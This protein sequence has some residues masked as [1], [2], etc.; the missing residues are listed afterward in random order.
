MA[1]RH[2][3]T[4]LILLCILLPIWRFLPSL[5]V[6]ENPFVGYLDSFVYQHVA[7]GAL[8]AGAIVLLFGRRWG[9]SLAL[10]GL[11]FHI[12]QAGLHVTALLGESIPRPPFETFS[13]GFQL[14]GWIVLFIWLWLPGIQRFT[15]QDS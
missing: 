2:K 11:L 7:D 8:L 14:G 13:L 12:I 1:G 10:G 4:G 15:R 6:L 9:W 5:F 3:P